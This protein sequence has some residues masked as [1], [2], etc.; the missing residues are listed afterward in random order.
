VPLHED[1][2]VGTPQALLQ[3][4]LGRLRSVEVEP[5][6]SLLLLTS[7]TFRGQPRTGDDRLVRL[8]FTR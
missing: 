7:N 4:R 5:D 2:S 3:G 1:G 8:T 6:G